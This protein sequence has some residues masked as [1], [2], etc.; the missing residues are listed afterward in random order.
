M[1]R[2]PGDVGIEVHALGVGQNLN[3]LAETGT[4]TPAGSNG[5][6]TIPGL[7]AG[8]ADGVAQLVIQGFA[9]RRLRKAEIEAIVLW[10]RWQ[11]RLEVRRCR[12]RRYLIRGGLR[13]CHLTAGLGRFGQIG[14]WALGLGGWHRR[15]GR[16]FRL[17]FRHD[18]LKHVAI[19]V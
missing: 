15:R 6:A 10:L 8:T 16:N 12:L 4:A 2:E 19:H 18:T 11:N 7:R 13:G 5:S 14:G 3:A 1:W 9:C 17:N